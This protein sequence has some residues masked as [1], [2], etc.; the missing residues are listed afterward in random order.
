MTNENN[1]THELTKREELILA[2]LENS[3]EEGGEALVLGGILAGFVVGS[4]F[5]P[6]L[7]GFLALAISGGTLASQFQRGRDRMKMLSGE[8]P[9]AGKLEGEDLDEYKSLVGEEQFTLELSQLQN[10][11]Y[12]LSEDAAKLVRAN[13]AIAIN[14]VEQL[15][16]YASRNCLVLGIGGDGKDFLVS[17]AIRDIKR[18]Q[19]E[20]KLFIIDPK[21]LQTEATYYQGVADV[22]RSNQCG[23]TSD[24]NAIAWFKQVFEEWRTVAGKEGERWLLIVTETTL[25]GEAFSRSKDNYL[26]EVISKQLTTGGGFGK[27]CWVLAQFP[28]LADL[29]MSN[30]SRSQLNVFAVVK[31]E[32]VTT[33]ASQW[34]RTKII[35]KIDHHELEALCEAS[36]VNRCFYSPASGRWSMMPELPNY[37]AYNRDK[38]QRVKPASLAPISEPQAPTVIQDAPAQQST[39]SEVEKVFQAL[40]EAQTTD[41]IEALKTA[42][43]EIPNNQLNTVIDRIKQEA[44]AQRR[45]AII[46]KFSL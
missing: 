10:G 33:A 44:I 45:Y 37:S 3:Q 17:N 22:F 32:S 7:G 27:S 30:N 34:S 12:E 21:G 40:E 14:P 24:E 43:P 38:H 9:I 28:N 2:A 42:Y 20:I 13:S 5:N 6:F 41:I 15:A 1:Q 25:I 11:K 29:G 19:P 39:Q 35:G 26:K 46:S 23:E 18:E 31:R 36:P 8:L 16:M 4:V